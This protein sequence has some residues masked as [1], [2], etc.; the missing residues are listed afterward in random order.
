MSEDYLSEVA[1][2]CGCAEMWELLS[3][4]RASKRKETSEGTQE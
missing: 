3:Q 1:D 2:G 4:K